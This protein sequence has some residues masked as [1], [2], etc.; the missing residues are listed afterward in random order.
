MGR[1]GI[2]SDEA[3]RRSDE[4]SKESQ[5]YKKNG[6]DFMKG[7]CQERARAYLA[8]SLRE[9]RNEAKGGK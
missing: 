2:S 1:F 5:G 6:D 8:D 3:K 7:V 9:R 4:Y